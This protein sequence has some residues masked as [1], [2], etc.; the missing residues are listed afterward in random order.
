MF[1]LAVKDGKL[2]IVPH[3]EKLKE[4]DPRKGFIGVRE[5]DRLYILLPETLRP[6]L[7]LG[8]YRGLRLGEIRQL[9]WHKVDFN[10]GV[11]RLLPS[12]T[13][14]GKG[15]TIPLN[16]ELLNMLRVRQKHAKSTYVFGNG[17]PLGSFRKTWYSR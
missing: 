13:K 7:A 17:R 11:I 10:T 12:E 6:V 8:F 3:M 4:A 2:F 15:R 16:P 5:Y 9:Q 1:R 14:S